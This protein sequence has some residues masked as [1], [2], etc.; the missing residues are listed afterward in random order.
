MCRVASSSESPSAAARPS[1]FVRRPNPSGISW[2]LDDTILFGQSDGIL[3]VSANGGTPEL[4]I[5]ATEG[6][7]MDGPQLLPDGESVLFSVTTATGTT[8]WDQA[9]IVVQS[10]AT[11]ERNGRAVRRE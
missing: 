8:R 1:S 10:L 5:P 7:Q 4:I 6:E 2:A 11:G 3:R 9:Q